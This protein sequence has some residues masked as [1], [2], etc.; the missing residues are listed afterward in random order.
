MADD[1]T[2][3]RELA[4]ELTSCKLDYEGALWAPRRAFF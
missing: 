4:D 2:L 1:S 3:I